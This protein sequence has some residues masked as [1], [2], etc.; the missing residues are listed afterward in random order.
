MKRTTASRGCSADRASDPSR[1]ASCEPDQVRVGESVRVV[2]SP[3][4]YVARSSFD[5]TR[6]PRERVVQ[7]AGGTDGDPLGPLEGSGV[8]DPLT[9]RLGRRARPR[10]IP[11]PTRTVTTRAAV[12]AIARAGSR[13][14]VATFG[15]REPT[16]FGRSRLETASGPAASSSS[17]RCSRRVDGGSSSVWL[18]R[19]FR[20]A[21]SIRSSSTVEPPQVSP[22]PT[23]SP[24]PCRF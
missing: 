10:I 9:G 18:Y 13:R 2:A 11:P 1:L 17:W 19:K 14:A 15:S 8:G 22:G 23:R 21:R 5:E 12:A 7:D 24:S 6:G 3:I 4:A 20:R 16:A